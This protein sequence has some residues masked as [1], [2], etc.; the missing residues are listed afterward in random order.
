MRWLRRLV[1]V[2]LF[3][4]A[5]VLCWRFVHANQEPVFVDFLFL[6][7][8]VTAPLWAVLA[9][10]FGLG[11]AL[12]V[13]AMGFQTARL[14]LTKRRYRKLARDLESEVHQLRN[15]PLGAPDA[16]RTQAGDAAHEAR[17]RSG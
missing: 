3:V 4:G 1:V 14:A 15:L 9:A 17:T 16:A 5:F 7:G 12:G 10:S 8:D 13:L 2:A 6:G 11:V